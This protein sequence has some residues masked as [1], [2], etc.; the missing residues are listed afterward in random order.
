MD[1]AV[2]IIKRKMGASEMVFSEARIP[3][4]TFAYHKLM[5]SESSGRLRGVGSGVTSNQ[6]D[7]VEESQR[8]NTSLAGEPIRD[9]LTTT[10]TLAKNNKAYIKDAGVAAHT[11][12]SSHVLN[13]LNLLQGVNKSCTTQIGK[14]HISVTNRNSTIGLP[15]SH[16]LVNQGDENTSMGENTNTFGCSNQLNGVSKGDLN[17]YAFTTFKITYV[18]KVAASAVSWP[19]PRPL[20]PDVLPPRPLL[21]PRLPRPRPHEPQL[22][23]YTMISKQKFFYGDGIDELNKIF[24]K[25]P[26][27]SRMTLTMGMKK[28]RNPMSRNTRVV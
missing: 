13:Q 20:P 3:T 4:E 21:P 2:N 23:E 15:R 19:V 11:S 22:S 26:E 25:L 1:I 14:K 24:K 8:N 12:R 17:F 6:N 7:D 5:G 28:L 10:P 27:N 18:L 9:T 16:N